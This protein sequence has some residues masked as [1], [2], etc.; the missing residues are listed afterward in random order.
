MTLKYI[1]FQKISK[2]ILI[3]M[4]CTMIAFVIWIITVFSVGKT[5]ESKT[6]ADESFNTGSLLEVD[7]YQSFIPQYGKIAAISIDIGKNAE[8]PDAGKIIISLCNTDLSIIKSQEIAV[9]TMK[10]YALT[11]IPVNWE[12]SPGIPYFLKVGCDNSEGYSPVIHYRDKNKNNPAE[13]L[14]LYYGT[15][16]IENGTL[17]ICYQYDIPL[18]KTDAAYLLVGYL[19]VGILVAGFVDIKY[20]K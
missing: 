20:F 9:A 12:V 13:N 11:E 2:A 5:V 16:I 6:L 3:Y 18:G 4:I 8:N 19:F 15:S 17:N 10:D 7:I 1:K 14:D